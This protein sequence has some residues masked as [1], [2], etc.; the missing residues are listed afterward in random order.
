MVIRL[1]DEEWYGQIIREN[2]NSDEYDNEVKVYYNIRDHEVELNSGDVSFFIPLSVINDII[3]EIKNDSNIKNYELVGELVKTLRRT[4]PES[5][6]RILREFEN[7]FLK[8]KE[9]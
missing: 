2:K 8:N 6:D 9:D 3:N 7:M 4:P 5:H 1:G